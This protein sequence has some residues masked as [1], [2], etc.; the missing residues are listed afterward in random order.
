MLLFVE[1]T[2]LIDGGLDFVW[3]LHHLHSNLRFD[4]NLPELRQSYRA[5]VQLEAHRR[6]LEFTLGDEALAE[7]RVEL[8]LDTALLL[9]RY[10]LDRFV[11][12]LMINC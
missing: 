1:V 7:Q 10:I 5:I 12:P 6:V 4:G 3:V 9:E 8:A 11:P 2:F